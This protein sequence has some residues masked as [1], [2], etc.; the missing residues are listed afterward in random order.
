MFNVD[1]HARSLTGKI[2]AIFLIA[3]ISIGLSWV[4][5]R[6]A[7]GK[8]MTT[9]E[10][11]TKPNDKL[12]ILK[13][14]SQYIATIGQD[15]REQILQNPEK[16]IPVDLIASDQI[17]AMLDTLRHLSVANEKQMEIID[18][19]E[20]VIGNYDKLVSDYLKTYATFFDNKLL[21]VKFQRLSDMI[22]QNV[23]KVDSNVITTELKQ[24]TTTI[25]PFDDTDETIEDKQPSFIKRIFGGKKTET[26]APETPLE[27]VRN[28]VSVRV[29]TLVISQRD[30][31][32]RQIEKSIQKIDKFN[33]ERNLQMADSELKLIR[34]VNEYFDVL[35]QLLRIIELEELDVINTSN[36][37]MRTTLNDEMMR[38]STVLVLFIV[39]AFILA[40]FIFSDISRSNLYR[41][42]LLEAKDE[43]EHLGL[44]KQRFLSNLS[45][46]IRTPLQSII[47]FSEQLLTENKPSHEYVE[48][49]NQSANH[50]LH[51]VNEVLDYSRIT[52][53]KFKFETHAFSINNV[54]AEIL[55][56]MKHQSLQKNIDFIYNPL[57]DVY[58]YYSGDAF[59]LKQILYNII[60][61]AIKFTDHGTVE[62][63]IEADENDTDTRFR[64]DIID[65]GQGISESDLKLIFNEFE[66]GESNKIGNKNG[67]GL[68]LSI[69]KTLVELQKGSLSV[70][71]KVGVGSVFT[72][73]LTY[74]KAS[75]NEIISAKST[76]NIN[77]PEKISGKVLLIDDDPFIVKLCE[78]IFQKYGIVYLCE[79]SS[80]QLLDSSWDNDISIVFLDIR[81]PHIDGIEL[82]K[83]LRKKISV[84]TK[85]VAL[86]AHA[87]PEE[88]ESIMKQGFDGLIVKP[89]KENDLLS[90]LNMASVEFAN[91]N[92]DV[93]FDLTYLRSFCMDDDALLLKSLLMFVKE[94][95]VDL[96]NVKQLSATQDYNTMREIVH[97]LAGRIGQ[98]GDTKLSNEYRKLEKKLEEN[99]VGSSDKIW[100]EMLAN[101]S[102]ELIVKIEKEV[103]ILNR[104]ITQ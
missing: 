9:V 5:S 95:K 59:R 2:I 11:V 81:M 97:K 20:I 49:I 101:E 71:S 85:I 7:F 72:F 12:R 76:S 36:S 33:L 48:V 102:E 65:S 17:L 64:F 16:I 74:P 62:L 40:Y 24:T 78:N 69:V 50:L 26:K 104:K 52:S 75:E 90:W 87:L 35:Q 60:G 57:E 56:I 70:T 84:D 51:I 47:G 19:V 29:D 18:S 63:K 21:S 91:K 28:E 37:E 68:G 22:A 10:A 86:T 53:G 13:N 42:Q 98:V 14:L 44:V 67:T 73:D 88:Q 34:G 4:I 39:I 96:E 55:G 30:S 27:I 80:Q 41:K 100:L 79:T 54:I 8:I 99:S 6:A 94:T 82:C 92:E 46:E 93:Y 3:V 66:Q 43:A 83:L 38:I 25:F 45:H 77:L 31:L 58:P 61:N 103:A 23:E 89:F 32:I 15:Q 1:F